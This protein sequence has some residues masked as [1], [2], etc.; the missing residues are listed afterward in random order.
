MLELAPSERTGRPLSVASRAAPRGGA[1]AVS[2][3]AQQLGW[4]ASPAAHL[5]RP[6]AGTET[7]LG[8]SRV[9]V[10]ALLTAAEQDSPRAHALV[11][12]LVHTGLRIDEA[13]AR[14]IGHWRR[15]A[16]HEVLALERKGGREAPTVLPG[17][18]VR[19]LR[20]T[21]T[22]RRGV[23]AEDA[24]SAGGTAPFFA[25]AGGGRMDQPAAWRLLRRLAVAAGIDPVER[26]S[27]HAL[28]HA[29]ITLALMPA[30][31][32][33]MCR[34]PPGTPTPPPPAP[35]RLPAVAPTATPPSP[36][37]PTSPRLHPPPP[38]AREHPC[39][40][41][42][43]PPETHRGPLLDPARHTRPRLLGLVVRAPDARPDACHRC[44][45][46]SVSF[47]V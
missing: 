2:Y 36:S 3:A 31:R 32:F 16:G 15:E 44:L 9:E 12:L 7:P 39:R 46:R 27:P 1:G 20:A 30:R 22:S 34:T 25:T 45:P 8:P 43:K 10:A 38:S 17:P 24:A 40:G 5:V 6:R 42:A 33:A 26:V 47:G 19:A 35:T 11:S 14:D 13:L 28:R 23:A 4:P 37:A 41:A 21:L 29:F 18:V